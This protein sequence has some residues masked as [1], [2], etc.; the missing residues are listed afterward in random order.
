[1][2]PDDR[3]EYGE[4]SRDIIEGLRRLAQGVE[5][6]PDLR[7]DVLARGERLLPSRQGGRPRWWA[8]VAG[9]RPHP[10]AWGPVVA[11]A[12]FIAGIFTSWPRQDMPPR[13][14]VSEERSAPAARLLPQEAIEAPPASPAMPSQPPKQEFRQQ[15]EPAPAP[16]E[17]LQTLARHSTRHIASPPHTEVTTTLPAALYEQLQQ[18]AQ[19]R[20]VSLPVILREA[21]EA[22]ARSPKQED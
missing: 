13:D 15:A 1:M 16:A 19:R 6:P 11:G 21:L 12:F 7:S 10:L 18:E 22:Y 20:R 4:E 5:T 17:P 9:W 2:M 8:I 14:I 3:E